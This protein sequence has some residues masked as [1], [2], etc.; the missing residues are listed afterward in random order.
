[1]DY[2]TR[3]LFRTAFEWTH[4]RCVTTNNV[5]KVLLQYTT[6]STSSRQLWRTELGQFIFSHH[7]RRCV[8]QFCGIRGDA[9]HWG[10]ALQAGRSR[11]RFPMGV[12]KVIHSVFVSCRTTNLGSTQPLTEISSKDL[13]LARA[14]AG[15][16]GGGVKAAGM[17]RLSED[18]WS[19]NGLELSGPTWA[20]T[21]SSFIKFCDYTAFLW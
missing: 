10:T 16:G 21:D 4:F 7:D 13:T 19:L 9:I 5:T 3:I 14:G 20:Y 15:A 12:F 8:I 17:R 6:L 11:V 18:S 1:V 2:E